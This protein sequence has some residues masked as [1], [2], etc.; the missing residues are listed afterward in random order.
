MMNKQ[1]RIKYAVQ[2]GEEMFWSTIADLFPDCP[3]GDFPPGDSIALSEFMK[4]SVNIWIGYNEDKGFKKW[5]KNT[6][7]KPGP[8]VNYE[9]RWFIGDVVH[10][11]DDLWH[12]YQSDTFTVHSSHGTLTVNKTTGDV[13]SCESNEKDP[14]NYIKDIERIDLAEFKK[15]WGTPIT[16]DVDILN[17][18]YWN[19]DNSYD[20]AENSWREECKLMRAGKDL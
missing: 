1:D 10:T 6:G 14:D 15:Y 18:A 8:T 20:I 11:I 9:P 13:I 16:G 12:S 2:R 7:V 4:E 19:K 5:C 3:G 17:V